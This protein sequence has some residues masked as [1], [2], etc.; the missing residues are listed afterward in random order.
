ML[1]GFVRVDLKVEED[2]RYNRTF[3]KRVLE[4]TRG[5][6]KPKNIVLVLRVA[7]ISRMFLEL[8]LFDLIYHLAFYALDNQ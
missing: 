7:K 4:R 1:T 3:R 2:A 8:F 5:E 6:Y